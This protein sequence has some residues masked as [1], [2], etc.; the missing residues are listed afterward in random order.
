MT[1]I[2]FIKT[3]PFKEGFK[4]IEDELPEI[5]FEKHILFPEVKTIDY[6]CG[7]QHIEYFHNDELIHKKTLHTDVITQIVINKSKSKLYY[8]IFQESTAYLIK[9]NRTVKK[10]KAD[11]NTI[12]SIG[13]Y[14][15]SLNKDKSVLYLLDDDLKYKKDFSLKEIR[16]D[17]ISELQYVKTNEGYEVYISS[18]P[19]NPIFKY[20]MN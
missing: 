9:S 16:F 19:D 1:E 7:V 5:K 17:R 2:K 13:D 20:L 8:E 6:L 14:F 3:I 18:G 4:W 11:G 12:Y 10:K 15:F